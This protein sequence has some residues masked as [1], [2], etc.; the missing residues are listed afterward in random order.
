MLAWVQIKERRRRSKQ[1]VDDD[2][3]GDRMMSD[4]AKE[5]MDQSNGVREEKK[6]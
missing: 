4:K 2:D 5:K 3:D 6:R 1:D